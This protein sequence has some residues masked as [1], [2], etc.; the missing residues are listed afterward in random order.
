MILDSNPNPKS[1]DRYPNP[2]SPY[3]LTGGKG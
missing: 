2:K 1:D 3:P